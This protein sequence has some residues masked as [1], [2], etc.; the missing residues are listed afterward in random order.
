MCLS[1]FLT[2]LS[3]YEYG[4]CWTACYH[5]NNVSRNYPCELLIGI[6]GLVC[7]MCTCV[8]YM[9]EEGNCVFLYFDKKKNLIGPLFAYSLRLTITYVEYG[10]VYWWVVHKWYLYDLLHYRINYRCKCFASNLFLQL[11]KHLFYCIIG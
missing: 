10:C 9:S 8:M 6:Y 11:L 4:I 2:Q 7:N 5:S 3:N 1:V